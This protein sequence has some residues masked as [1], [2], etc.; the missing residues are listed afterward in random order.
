MRSSIILYNVKLK[1]Q[2]FIK[3]LEIRLNL[4]GSFV[5]SSL[6][7]SAL[8]HFYIFGILVSVLRPRPNL[9][10]YYNIITIILRVS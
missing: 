6:W 9:N 7:F 4:F 5:F 1:N 8:F 10:R 2:A 3:A